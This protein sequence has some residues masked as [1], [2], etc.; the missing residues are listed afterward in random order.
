MNLHS[1]DF[2]TISIFQNA[3][4]LVNGVDLIYYGYSDDRR[5]AVFPLTAKSF[6]E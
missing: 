4:N 2:K 1:T 5:T 6:P 3:Q